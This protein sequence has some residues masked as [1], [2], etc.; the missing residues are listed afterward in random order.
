MA[1]ESRYVSLNQCAH[2]IIINKRPS[3]LCDANTATC[4]WWYSMQPQPTRGKINKMKRTKRGMTAVT[5]S[6]PQSTT[7]V[8]TVPIK[9]LKLQQVMA[10]VWA[11]QC[12]FLSLNH[13]PFRSHSHSPT[14]AICRSPFLLFY[15][16]FLAI[17]TIY[18]HPLSL[19]LLSP[20]LVT[21][22]SV[23][24]QTRSFAVLSICFSNFLITLYVCSFCR[25]FFV[26]INNN[27]NY[28]N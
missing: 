5:N 10:A 9:Q 2:I 3:N 26:F 6:V 8:T 16:R 18:L 28:H 14:V 15:I 13:T 11:I 22:S 21:V 7:S 17:Y 20:T 27:N 12:A 24:T 19:H 25:S 23:F 4:I 1:D